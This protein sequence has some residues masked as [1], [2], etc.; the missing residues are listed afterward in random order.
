MKLTA[1]NAFNLEEHRQSRLRRLERENEHLRAERVRL[2]RLLGDTLK[3]AVGGTDV[4][5]S[6]LLEVLAERRGTNLARP[7]YLEQRERREA[8]HRMDTVVRV[9]RET[10]A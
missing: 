3:V 2:E 8:E 6:A 9:L 4:T 5:P 10:A 1:F 7:A